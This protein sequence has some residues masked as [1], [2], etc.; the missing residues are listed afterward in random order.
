MVQLHHASRRHYD[1]RCRWACPEKLG[2]AKGPELRTAVKRMAVEVEDHPVDYATFQGDIP[3]ASTAAAMSPRRQRGVG[4]RRRSEAGLAKG[5]LRFE[6][7]GKK[8]REVGTG[9]FGQAG[10]PAAMVL[11]RT[12]TPMPAASRPMTCW[13]T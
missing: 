5:H 2:G 7:F 8:L 1:F 3:K 13:S 4:K 6:L 10:P 12:R 9:A 11:F